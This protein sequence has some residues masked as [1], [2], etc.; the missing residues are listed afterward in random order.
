MI[1]PKVSVLGTIN[2]SVI[3][4]GFLP[5]DASL[6]PGG[7]TVVFPTDH[8]LRA[9]NA[10]THLTT[11]LVTGYSE[12]PVWSPAGDLIAFA[13][14]GDQGQ[15]LLWSVKMDQ[16]TGKPLEPA[17]RLS[18]SATSGSSPQFSPDGKFVAFVRDDGGGKSS[19]VE[20]PAAGGAEKV[21]AV[22]A[23]IARLRWT[24]NGASI[25]YVD[26][27]NA[28][29][30]SIMYRVPSS[31]GTAQ[32]VHD[33]SN[34]FD[35]PGVTSDG[36]FAELP[37]PAT[38]RGNSIVLADLSGR[39]LARVEWPSGVWSTD[40]SGGYRL[41]G[42]QGH[43][44]RALRVVSLSD[45]KVREVIGM[46]AESGAPVW[47]PDGKKIAVI[48]YF[49]ALP[50]LV[51]MKPDGSEMKKSP[52]NAP[53]QFT[54]Q[55]NGANFAD[56]RISPDGRRA[57]FLGANRQSLEVMDL[58]SGEQRQL[59][60][61][62]KLRFA[63]SLIWLRNSTGVRYVFQDRSTTPPTRSVREVSLD[64]SDKLVRLVPIGELGRAILLVDQDTVEAFGSGK[65]SFLPLD[66][67]AARTVFEA[68]VVG[69]GAIS[70]DRR[71][72]V[73]RPGAFVTHEPVHGIT[74]VNLGDLSQK[75]ID[76]P[77]LDTGNLAFDPSGLHVFTPGRD[78]P[79]GA[80][81]IYE[82]ST[83]SGAKRVVASMDTKEHSSVFS[84]SPDGKWLAYTVAGM[85]TATF[86]TLDLSDAV[87]K[88]S[89]QG[90]KH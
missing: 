69:A 67:G 14:A 48:A 8:D 29:Q 5:N 41:A 42:V 37:E 55:L 61:P 66:G 28:L 9:F 80:L 7:H 53:P 82:I 40:W 87:A 60:P 34:V 68:P 90:Q 31:G 18:L 56:L 64:K 47:F 22:G 88:L 72:L 30:K 26:F 84:V 62:L 50:F 1:R 39:P 23:G 11:V 52:M 81:H 85:P 43:N 32:A 59:V 77:F 89:Q 58:T 45:G 21:L 17:R 12:N 74:L 10:S 65:F 44:P 27:V 86:L 6:S 63:N 15:E 19:L 33:Y 38:A 46:G 78:D 75:S 36:K 73:L 71:T 70:S 4:G 76:L 51:T 79:A 83:Q 2:D 20:V 16:T 13:H 25:Y 3:G 49:N 24:A 57:A 35:P 54:N